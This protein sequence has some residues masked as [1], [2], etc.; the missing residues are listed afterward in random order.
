MRASTKWY[1]RSSSRKMIETQLRASCST[2]V[3]GEL[4]VSLSFRKDPD[5]A[6]FRVEMDAAEARLLIEH[7]TYYVRD[8]T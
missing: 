5:D 6:V 7:L 8:R 4:T 2:S 1:V 3:D